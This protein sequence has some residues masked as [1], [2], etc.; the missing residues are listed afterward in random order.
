MHT[1]Y[2]IG[3]NT[4]YIIDIN[5]HWYHCCVQYMRRKEKGKK[6]KSTNNPSP[7][8]IATQKT[9]SIM[10]DIG[11][12]KAKNTPLPIYARKKHLGKE[13]EIKKPS[14]AS[15]LTECSEITQVG[16]YLSK[17]SSPSLASCSIT[18]RMRGQRGTM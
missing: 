9:H 12:K 18:S 4:A 1:A 6:N 2:A 7:D 15:N 13:K 8:Q 17:N 14:C 5:Y 10:Q 16:L 11:E 3:G